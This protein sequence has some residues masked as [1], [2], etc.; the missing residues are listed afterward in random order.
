MHRV[1]RARSKCGNARSTASFTASVGASCGTVTFAWYFNG[2]LLAGETSTT[3]T[4]SSVQLANAGAYTLKASNT[5]GTT[6]SDAAILTVNRL[7]LAQDDGAA[8]P[9][10][11]ALTLTV[12]KLLANDSDADGDTLTVAS[13]STTS[14]NGGS[15][16]LAGGN[17]TYTPQPAFTGIDRFSYTISDGRGGEATANVEIFVSAGALPADNSMTVAVVGSEIRIR[18][19]GVAGQA[20]QLQRNTSLNPDDWNTIDTRVAPLHGIVEFS[21]N[22]NLPGAFYRVAKP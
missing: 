3:L 20:Y 2:D 1:A 22:A 9:K 15:V 16:T 12:A 8:T 11:Q 13:V 14:T 7:P 21:D 4:I 19:A 17:A 6:T 5:A 10:D 18:F